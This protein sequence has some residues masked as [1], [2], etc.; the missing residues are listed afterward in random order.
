MK[1]I[2]M[3]RD[4]CLSG[5]Q[6]QGFGGVEPHFRGRRP[7][8]MRKKLNVSTHRSLRRGG[9]GT[10]RRGSDSKW[11]RSQRQPRSG[12]RAKT[13]CITRDP[14]KSERAAEIRRS[15]RSSDDGRDNITLPEQR[16]RGPRWRL[17]RPDASSVENT[18]A[19]TA[20][21]HEGREG[22]VKPTNLRAYAD[23]ALE[24]AVVPGRTSLTDEAPWFEAVPGKT[25]RTEF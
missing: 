15:G 12:R 11:G 25:R 14:G 6:G 20:G 23:L 17:E 16:T 18:D 7:E 1:R 4:T 5:S 21:R 13:L 3:R 10:W 24:P 22:A 8:M 19:Q 9:S 2:L